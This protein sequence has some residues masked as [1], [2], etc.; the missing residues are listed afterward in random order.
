MEKQKL[1][2]TDEQ[3]MFIKDFVKAIKNGN[4][5]IFAG[6]GL[7]IPSGTM[8][9]SD[10]LV[11][12][13]EDLKLS[14]DKT[15]DMATMAQYYEN[16]KG[17]RNE[18]SEII[19]TSFKEYIQPNI[20]Q[21]LIAQ[22]PIETLW[23]TNYDDLL[24]QAYK[25]EFKKTLV[26]RSPEDFSLIN[27]KNDVVIYKMHGDVTQPTRAVI[28]KNDYETYN[29]THLVYT[30]ALKGDL[31]EK[32]FLFIGFSFDDPNLNYILA[33]IKALVGKNKPNHYFFIEKVKK[34]KEE[35]DQD[36]DLR[37]TK[38]ELKIEDLK[39]YG[40]KAV[41]LE[42]YDDITEILKIIKKMSSLNNIFISGAKGPDRDDYKLLDDQLIKKVTEK[43]V[44]NENKLISGYGLEVGS[45]VIDAVLDTV[46]KN[47]W[48][49]LDDHLEIYPFSQIQNFDAKSYR[50]EILQGVGLSI[51]FFGTKLKKD[52]CVTS[53]GMIDEFK[54]AHKNGVKI[55]PVG[56]TGGASEEI[57][58]MVMKHPDEYYGEDEQLIELI[59][60]L[61]ENPYKNAEDID[62][63]SDLIIKIVKK[64][65]LIK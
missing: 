41:L 32:K 56:C 3:K 34:K 46:S 35:L 50:K 7:S 4:A 54:L 65:Q 17:S 48:F 9:W 28:T 44:N 14:D 45:Q 57:F 5:A 15:T 25:E 21:K 31:V 24:E 18:I 43:L 23:T 62:K 27:R 37:K 12:V 2:L 52:E 13:A 33:R 26:K 47:P 55:I 53:D 40:I 39:R 64:M 6:A 58:K 8:S 60:Q 11:N 29:D 10:L 59:K 30:T 16:F 20:N 19:M 63:L 1:V 61:G 49:K 51:C 38:Q 22:L 36:F 42:S